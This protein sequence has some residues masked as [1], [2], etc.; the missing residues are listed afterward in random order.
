MKGITY[1]FRSQLAFVLWNEQRMHQRVPERHVLQHGHGIS[2][3]E[4]ATRFGFTELKSDAKAGWITRYVASE[5]LY[6]GC[7]SKAEWWK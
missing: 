3:A 4:N 5:P 6:L 7:R 2:P 1:D